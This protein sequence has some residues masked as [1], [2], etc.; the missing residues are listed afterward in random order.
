MALITFSPTA[1]S[2]ILS[3]N[4]LAI[5][6]FTSA[7][8]SAL[9]ISFIVAA[10]LSSVIL[11]SPFNDLNADSSLSL[12]DS[13]IKL[14]FSSDLLHNSFLLNLTLFPLQRQGMVNY[15][16]GLKVCVNIKGECMNNI[17]LIIRLQI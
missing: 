12:N 9:R 10:I 6:K 7:S 11:A 15:K 2:F 14:L 13:N 8:I 3:V 1:L 4:S 17:H 16:G 5:L